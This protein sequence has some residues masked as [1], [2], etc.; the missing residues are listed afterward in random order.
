MV[1]FSRRV[2]WA[3]DRRPRLKER[4]RQEVESLKPPP[5]LSLHDW[6]SKPGPGLWTDRGTH[7]AEWSNIQGWSLT[8]THRSREVSLEVE[9]AYQLISRQTRD[10]PC[11][12]R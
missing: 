5:V 10:V 4:D 1:V 2:I 6:N 12:T 7:L 8:I 3:D 9:V 11:N